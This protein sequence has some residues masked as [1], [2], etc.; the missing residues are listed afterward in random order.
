M[1]TGLGPFAFNKLNW[2]ELKDCSVLNIVS[3]KPWSERPI[4]L[5]STGSW[6]EL[7]RIVRAIIAPDALWSLLRLRKTEK[8]IFFVSRRVLNMF[9]N[10]ATELSWVES[11]L[12]LWSRPK[13]EK[14]LVATHQLLPNDKSLHHCRASRLV[15]ALPSLD[16]PRIL[17]AQRRDLLVDRLDRYGHFFCYVVSGFLFLII[18]TIGLVVNGAQAWMFVPPVKIF[19]RGRHQ[20]AYKRQLWRSRSCFK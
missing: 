1:C 4:R 8:P 15:K 16:E 5:N 19:D 12:A 2:T 13:L 9:G 14:K 6:V 20:N 11:D 3:L 7:S 18:V 10:Y 17:R